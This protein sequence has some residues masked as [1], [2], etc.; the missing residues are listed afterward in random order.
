MHSFADHRIIGINK[1]DEGSTVVVQGRKDYVFELEKR[2]RDGQL[3][4]DVSFK[5]IHTEKITLK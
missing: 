1:T 3:Y 4:K 2:L 5:G